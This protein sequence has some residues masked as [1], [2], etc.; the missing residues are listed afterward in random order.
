MIIKPNIIITPDCPTVVFREPKEK[1]NLDEELP[2]ILRYQGW[3]C[4]TYFNVQFI[5]SGELLSCARFVVSFEKNEMVTV[6]TQPGIISSKNQ[7]NYGF[8]QL[9]AWKTP[10]KSAK[11]A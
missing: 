7:T 8:L 4:G 9:E 11:A 1:I 10:K 3:G 2:K 6:E 5:D